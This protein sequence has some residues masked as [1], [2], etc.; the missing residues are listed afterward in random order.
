MDTE[1]HDPEG[2]R[3]VALHGDGPA[4]SFDDLD[5]IDYATCTALQLTK[6]L[7]VYNSAVDPAASRFASTGL[8]Q[9]RVAATPHGREWDGSLQ[10]RLVTASF[11]SG[12]VLEDRLALFDRLI[13]QPFRRIASAWIGIK[14]IVSAGIAALIASGQLAVALDL[15]I[16]RLALSIT[17]GTAWQFPSE[18]PRS[19][20]RDRREVLGCLAGHTC[21]VIVLGG[22][23]LNLFLHG[24]V[25]WGMIV[26]GAIVAQLLSTLLRLAVL[27]IGVR[28]RRLRLERVAR[29]GGVL[30]ALVVGVC[31][32]TSTPVEAIPW[33]AVIAT[34][35]VYLYA[36]I[37][38]LRTY[39]KTK[40]GE[41]LPVIVGDEM[42]WPP[43]DHYL[44]SGNLR[45]AATP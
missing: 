14:I 41:R 28:L 23:M 4:L 32:Q 29:A 37:E 43:S 3:V 44:E 31:L 42:L 17:S 5:E 38:A 27:Q 1:P 30:V 34:T 40:Y 45:A 8:A 26:A 24:R 15:L 7:R 39:L 13:Y 16:I 12:A 36:L 10:P 18:E 9:V 19:Q 6:R 25:V 35:P 11:V 22:V 21:D 2:A 33:V 20:A